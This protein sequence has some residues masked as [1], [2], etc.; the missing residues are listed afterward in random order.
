MMSRNFTVKTF[1]FAVSLFL[2]LVLSASAHGGVTATV[3]R[4][5]IALDETL[6]LTISKDS[7]SFFSGPDLSPVER[8][9]EVLGQ[10]QS[11]STKIINGN[12][13]SSVRW[14]IVLAPKRVGTLQIPSLSVG[15][16][17]T[18]PL[19]VKVVKQAEPK[20]KAADASIFIE[21][22]VDARSVYV[23]SQLIYTL[24]IYVIPGTQV[25]DPG[26]PQLQDAVVEKLDDTSFEKRI[27]GRLYRVFELRYAVFPQKSGVLE[28]P[29]MVVKATLPGQQRYRDFFD[30]FGSQGKTVKL[31]SKGE[32]VTVREKP[33]SYPPS[34]TWLPTNSLSIA[35][36]WSRN[37][38]DLKVG[39]S[40]TITIG[41]AGE[42]LLGSQLPPIEI[43]EVDGIKLYQ[44]K[45]EVQNHPTS[46]GITGI[47]QESIALIPT[48]PGTLQLPEIRIPWWDKQTSKVEYAVIPARELIITGEVE[49]TAQPVTTPAAPV[50]PTASPQVSAPE[51][52]AG[53]GPVLWIVACAVLAIVWLVTLFLLVRTRRQVALPASGVVRKEKE[54][55]EKKESE[56]FK[57]LQNSC[58]NNDPL[59]ARNAV[60]SWAN[61]A[62]PEEK[63]HSLADLERLLP[64]R[65][66]GPVLK[67][68]DA[69]LYSRSEGASV[70]Q[71]SRLLEKVKEIR[72]NK[73]KGKGGSGVLEPLYR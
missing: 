3:D 14:N 6:N 20:T 11:S 38:R 9:F 44:G 57:V 22:D 7:S 13:T 19:T 65:E 55:Q 56:T 25:Q 58:R 42:G 16:E 4:T 66:L 29:R 35:D 15:K 69:C 5:T 23:Q 63:V 12:V 54:A 34:A 49:K 46:D 59:A 68:I 37:P 1:S 26:V 71:G 36:D 31:R 21:T 28:I 52:T 45:A 51:S 73:K 64:D 32:K 33:D 10:N 27:D 30:P 40:T 24:R 67:E 72:K 53:K 48:R 41:M 2:L 70:W 61:A 47:R 8:D 60:I 17:K 43:A 62:W 39:E 50:T 18:R